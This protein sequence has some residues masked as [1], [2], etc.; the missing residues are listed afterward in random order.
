MRVTQTL[1]QDVSFLVRVL[2][3]G[4]LQAVDPPI[5]FLMEVQYFNGVILPVNAG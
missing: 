3:M 1:P 2:I 5:L 4:H